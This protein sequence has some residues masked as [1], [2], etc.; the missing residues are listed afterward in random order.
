MIAAFESASGKQIPY[1]ITGRRPATSPNAML[2][3]HWP[4][5]TGLAN[6]N[7]DIEAMCEDTWRW[8]VANP[9]G[10]T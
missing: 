10:Y 3:R 2:T 8:Q 5:G 4:C 7:S 9:Q 6:S 1:R